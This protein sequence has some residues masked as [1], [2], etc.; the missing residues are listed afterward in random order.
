MKTPTTTRRGLQSSM[1][2]ELPNSLLEVLSSGSTCT[3]RQ[4][5]RSFDTA[6]RTCTLTDNDTHLSV[7]RVL[8][9]PPDV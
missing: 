8:N 7:P 2:P 9:T 6:L 3:G 1:G 5:D 4:T